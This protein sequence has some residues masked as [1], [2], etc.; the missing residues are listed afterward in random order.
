M[1]LKV[2]HSINI[3]LFSLLLL[4]T[5]PVLSGM[6]YKITEGEGATEGFI[7]KV[8]EDGILVWEKFVVMD[9]IRRSESITAVTVDEPQ[10]KIHYKEV[11]S[12]GSLSSEKTVTIIEIVNDT[13]D[14]RED[15]V[16]GEPKE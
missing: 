16:D 2:A 5:P 7:R 9:D 1:Q 12:G 14:N 3:F 15:F 4:N 10:R 13:S 6:S 11:F 8:I